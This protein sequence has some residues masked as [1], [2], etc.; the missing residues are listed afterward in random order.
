VLL[1]NFY[2]FTLTYLTYSPFA[3]ILSRT[4][5]HAHTYTHS[6]SSSLSLSLPLSLF[7]ARSLSFIPNKFLFG[8]DKLSLRII[9]LCRVSFRTCAR[10]PYVF[11][12]NHL[13]IPPLC[14]RPTPHYP[15]LP[16]VSFLISQCLP[17]CLKP[18]R[19]YDLRLKLELTLIRF[20][21]VASFN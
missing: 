9:S 2:F 5:T 11:M 21:E 17:T 20:I 10:G 14:R 13:K 4:H 1:C 15:S 12:L 3:L 16:F 7:R 6:F 19:N 8:L 18:P